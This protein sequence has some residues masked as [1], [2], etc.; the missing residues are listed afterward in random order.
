MDC[1]GALGGSLG[2]P[3]PRCRTRRCR[4]NDSA[5]FNPR[6]RGRDRDCRARSCFATVAHCCFHSLWPRFAL[7]WRAHASSPRLILL[8]QQDFTANCFAITATRIASSHFI[9]RVPGNMDSTST[10]GV[11][12]QNGRQPTRMQP[13]CSPHPKGWMRSEKWAGCRERWMNLT[14]EFCTFRCCPPHARDSFAKPAAN[15]AGRN[16]Q[17]DFRRCGDRR[18][19]SRNSSGGRAR[20]V[21]A[22]AL[23]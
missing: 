6:G 1:D 5:Y 12:S 2:K 16:S 8:S 13:S 10:S 17:S 14:R 20:A 11:K 4:K 15:S 3:P 18:R 22:P 23:A 19:S 9:S 7:N 21:S